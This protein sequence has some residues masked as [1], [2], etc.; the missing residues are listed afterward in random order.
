MPDHLAV[1]L[2][3][4]AALMALGEVIVRVWRRRTIGAVHVGLP[5]LAL[6]V[7]ANNEPSP[8]VEVGLVVVSVFVMVLLAVDWRKRKT[9]QLR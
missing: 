4:A 5:T 7:V 6:A 2:A 1:A 8:F 3:L 9:V